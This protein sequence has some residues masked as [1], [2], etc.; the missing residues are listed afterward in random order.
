MCACMHVCVCV[1]DVVRRK[2]VCAHDTAP[3]MPVLSM[4]YCIC[5]WRGVQVGK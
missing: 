5:M 2:T 4:G 3:A 1:C